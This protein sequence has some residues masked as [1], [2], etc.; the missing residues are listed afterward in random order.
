MLSFYGIDRTDNMCVHLNQ[1]CVSCIKL[2]LASMLL[3][4][5]CFV[6]VIYVLASTLTL[7]YGAYYG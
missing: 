5:F 3:L 7:G 6:L 1:M 4:L 2:C